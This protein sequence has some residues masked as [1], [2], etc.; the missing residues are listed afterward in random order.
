M[1]GSEFPHFKAGMAMPNSASSWNALVDA[2]RTSRKHPVNA[3]LA[4][5]NGGEYSPST[6]LVYN[7][8]GSDV[9]QFAV[10]G[11]GDVRIAQADNEDEF[12]TRIHMIGEQPAVGTHDGKFCVTIDPIP[13]GGVGRAAVTGLVQCQ[14]TMNEAWHEYADI[15]DADS[16]KLASGQVGK[17][18]ILWSAGTTGDQW[19][20]VDVGG[21][22][23]LHEMIP[24][25]LTQ[26]GGT[27]GDEAT[28]ATWTYDVS[29]LGGN[30]IESALD[31]TATPHNA[32]REI[33]LVT[34]A[35]RGTGYYQVNAGGTA[36]EFVLH[37]LDESYTA[38]ACS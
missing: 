9:A 7:D 11:L 28:A 16:A 24:V 22:I 14:V 27:D 3:E 19:A 31:P 34:A 26:V 12:R 30:V 18:K 10:L 15:T 33:G 13:D 36:I 1:S 2:A 8:S 21:G 35:T 32:S 17:A 38:E 23:G 37:W 4:V 29:D 6:I 5:G 25:A 20:I